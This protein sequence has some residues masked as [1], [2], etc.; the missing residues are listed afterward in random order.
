MFLSTYFELISDKDHANPGYNHLIVPIEEHDSCI[1]L[2]WTHYVDYFV[3]LLGF[4][5]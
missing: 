5:E 2:L 4:R 3:D 1:N